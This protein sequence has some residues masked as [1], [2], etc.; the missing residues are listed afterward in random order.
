MVNMAECT[1]SKCEL[2][3]RS[4]WFSEPP[5]FEEGWLCGPL[6]TSKSLD[7]VHIPSLL[8]MFVF[9]FPTKLWVL[10]GQGTSSSFSLRAL[11]KSL[12][13]GT[14]LYYTQHFE[15]QKFNCVFSVTKHSHKGK[16]ER[17]M[18]NRK[19]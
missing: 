3:I 8:D 9:T 10:Q 13:N 19:L 4:V 18:H 15:K 2:D 1:P 14:K 5:K 7:S 16:R 11:N 17:L 6:R 12:L